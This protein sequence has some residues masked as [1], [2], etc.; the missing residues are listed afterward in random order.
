MDGR[1]RVRVQVNHED[2]WTT[3][4][5]M[6]TSSARAKHP[7]IWSLVTATWALYPCRNPRRV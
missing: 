3:D 7:S 6:V 4:M 5:V 1:R 2:T